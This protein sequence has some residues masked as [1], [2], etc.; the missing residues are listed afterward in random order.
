M[1]AKTAKASITIRW[2]GTEKVVQKQGI[3]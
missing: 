1:M 3:A 2:E